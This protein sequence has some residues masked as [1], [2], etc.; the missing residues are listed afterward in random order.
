MRLPDPQPHA[1]GA[2]RQQETVFPAE[3][4]LSSEPV[5]GAIPRGRTRREVAAVGRVTASAR[6]RQPNRP[7][8]WIALMIAGACCSLGV[9]QSCCQRQEIRSALEYLIHHAQAGEAVA[10]V[11]PSLQPAVEDQLRGHDV[12][13]IPRALASSLAAVTAPDEP[14]S[15]EEIAAL[16]N[17]PALWILQID[18]PGAQR[19]NAMV[20]ARLDAFMRL[21]DERAFAP[22]R[23]ARYVPHR[24]TPAPGPA[25]AGT[26]VANA[27]QAPEVRQPG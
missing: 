26:T 27:R 18:Q 24:N 12:P 3:P 15:E 5:N 19:V 6:G 10:C 25:A 16:R 7:R 22:I 1:R 11:T 13:V 20:R 14:T 21:T 9:Y 4:L 23:L 17:L 2:D 8:A